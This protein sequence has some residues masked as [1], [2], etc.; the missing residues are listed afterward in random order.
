MYSM[1]DKYIKGN[2]ENRYVTQGSA[3]VQE[4]VRI[5]SEL[6]CMHK[7]YSILHQTSLGKVEFLLHNSKIYICAGE[8]DDNM[9][10]L[11]EVD[12]KIKINNRHISLMLLA[13]MKIVS[14]LK[15]DC[16]HHHDNI[17]IVKLL[18]VP[19]SLYQHVLTE[20]EYQL[21]LEFDICIESTINHKYPNEF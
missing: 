13:T 4:V 17:H 19:Q 16:Y 6:N 15:N 18:C 2:V 5:R 8:H 1:R 14:C 20:F 9:I 7:Y 10:S 12:W 11:H 21:Q 3:V